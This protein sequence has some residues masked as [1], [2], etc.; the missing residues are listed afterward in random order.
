MEEVEVYID[1][2]DMYKRGEKCSVASKANKMAN[3]EA[4]GTQKAAR[5]VVGRKID[6]LLEHDQ[7]ELSGSE[8]KTPVCTQTTMERQHN[9]NIRVNACILQRILQL[10]FKDH[11]QDESIQ[12]LTMEW[13]GN[14][15]WSL[16]R[17]GTLG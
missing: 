5:A 10:P 9:K 11:E 16:L 17:I 14:D 2:Y 8:W 7:F 13:S 3:E 6:V 15:Y 12:V 1:S 4:H